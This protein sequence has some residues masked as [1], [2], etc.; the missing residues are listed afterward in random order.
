MITVVTTNDGTDSTVLYNDRTALNIDD[1]DIPEG[2]ILVG[3]IKL[4]SRTVGGA[5]AFAC[6]PCGAGRTCCAQLEQEAAG[7]A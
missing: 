5:V 3:T 4:Y 1:K 6:H 7:A 2:L